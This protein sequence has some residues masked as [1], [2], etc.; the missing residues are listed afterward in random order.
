MHL[1]SA[2]AVLDPKGLIALSER[3]LMVQAVG[4]M[5]IVAVPVYL[6]LFFFARKYRAGN[7]KAV[8]MP[9]WE[10]GKLE[11][12]IWWAI[13]FEIVLIL[14]ALT[15]GSTHQL[16]PRKPLDLAQG[17]PL[18]I[19]VV[20]LDWKW[21]FIYPEQ[22]IATVNYVRVPVNRPVEFEVTADAPMN[23]F[24]VPQLG[25]QIYAMTGMVNSLNLVAN[26]V[27]KY[28]GVSS[29]YSGSGFAQM[30]FIAEATSQS[31]FDA[32]VTLLKAGSTTLT[33]GAYETLA[34]P[35]VAVQPAYYSGVTSNLYDTIIMQFRDSPSAE[36]QTRTH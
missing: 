23:S 9:N 10:H 11:E 2:F 6:L 33:L 4:F 17:K 12:L 16:D 21:L 26:Q 5:L 31:D 25:G 8:Y 24:W 15:W 22:E 29:N 18:I 1:L 34:Q 14:G 35:S 3:D 28:T 19:E 7:T 27:G 30:R 32:W 13:P 36:M 20:A